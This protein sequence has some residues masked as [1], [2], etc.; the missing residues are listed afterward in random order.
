MSYYP[1][2][3]RPVE[4]GR[5]A[6]GIFMC[7]WSVIDVV[8]WSVKRQVLLD[9]VFL[10]SLP[11]IRQHST[12]SNLFNTLVAFFGCFFLLSGV[13]SALPQAVEKRDV[14]ADVANALGLGFVSS[15]ETSIGVSTVYSLNS[16]ISNTEQFLVNSST[17]WRP[18]KSCT[19]AHYL[20]RSQ[21]NSRRVPSFQ[22]QLWQ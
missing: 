19:W 5:R 11:T 9:E 13:V 1:S 18:T 22:R 15:I 2:V 8:S 14:I 3:G 20:L 10:T 6:K 21:R 7:I 17:L 12:M 16:N 4:R